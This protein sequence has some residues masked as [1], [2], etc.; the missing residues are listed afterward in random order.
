MRGQ[1]A[2]LYLLDCGTSN[3]ASFLCIYVIYCPKHPFLPM[4]LKKV[5]IHN[6]RKLHD[7]DINFSEKETLFVGANNSGKTS[8]IH[9]INN[10]L[11]KNGSSYFS[12]ED[13]PVHHWKSLNKLQEQWKSISP[14]ETAQQ[15]QCKQDFISYLP[16]L[17][18]TIHVEDKEQHLVKELIPHLD[19]EGSELSVLIRMEPKN[20]ENLKSAFEEA[21]EKSLRLY[22]DTPKIGIRKLSDFLKKSRFTEHLGLKYYAWDNQTN[23]AIEDYTLPESAVSKLFLIHVIEAQRGF[24]DIHDTISQKYASLSGQFGLY[25]RTHT[26]E[27]ILSERDKDI[28]KV[29]EKAN[30]ELND[31]LHTRYQICLDA[32][33][34]LNYPGFANPQISLNTAISFENI[35]N[36]KS[37][38]QF[39]V[40][41]AT[42]NSGEDISLPERYNG[43]GYRNL[44]SI[45][46]ELL[47]FRE[48]WADWFNKKNTES[49]EPPPIHLV[50]LEEPEAHLHVQAQKTFIQKAWEILTTPSTGN[51]AFPDYAQ[52]QLI[53]S[54]HSGHIAYNHDFENIRYFR[55]EFINNIPL[56]KIIGLNEINTNNTLPEFRAFV[57]QYLKLSYYDL[58]FADAAIL[59]EGKAERI[60]MPHFLKE[61][62]LDTQYITTI[63]VDGSYAH[64]F[65]SLLKALAIPCLVITDIDSSIS[66]ERKKEEKKDTAKTP[67]KKGDGLITRNSTLKKVFSSNERKLLF[68]D[69]LLDLPEEKKVFDNLRLCY[70]TGIASKNGIFY[71]YTFEDA[72]AFTNKTI[73]T[74]SGHAPFYGMLKKFSAILRKHAGEPDIC[75]EKLFE[76]ITSSGKSDFAMQLFELNQSR[77][78][79]TPA[80]IN[81]GLIWLR[82]MLTPNTQ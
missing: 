11:S 7:C 17:R 61:A 26:D 75:A 58:F 22:H 55:K 15:E 62:K 43:L 3:K 23:A 80:Y 36:P 32:L 40:P 73:L 25:I 8:A 78:L 69:E 37:A 71:P 45:T 76:K 21:K 77:Q 41:N 56:T 79:T 12:A 54:T 27:D 34:E 6:F 10:F 72:V 63:E 82:S 44:I 33:N 18:M 48:T 13:I 64:R 68:I 30:A 4:Y 65:F 38:V 52:T 28:I 9:A 50:L 46:L 51:D 60:L 5:H 49:E 29:I 39:S 16:L 57:S 24:S 20:W 70:Q 47:D 19:W 31:K 74:D 2:P 66:D 35:I 59:I 67:T 42:G 14:E 1:R 81:E 53:V